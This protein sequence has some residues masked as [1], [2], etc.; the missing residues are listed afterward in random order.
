MDEVA[1]F[2]DYENV[3]VVAKG[4]N[5]PLAEALIKYS[6]SLGHPRVKKVYSDWAGINKE[7]SKRIVLIS[8]THIALGNNPAFN[9]MMFRKGIEEIN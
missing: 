3:R 9:P 1:I 8:D 6:E 4:T 7:I 5:V 2:W